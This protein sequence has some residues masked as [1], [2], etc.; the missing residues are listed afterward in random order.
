MTFSQADVKRIKAVEQRRKAAQKAARMYVMNKALFHSFKSANTTPSQRSRIF[1]AKLLFGLYGNGSD[2]PEDK[3]N[4][5]NRRRWKK[6][7]KIAKHI[8]LCD[9]NEGLSEPADMCM[10]RMYGSEKIPDA[11]PDGFYDHW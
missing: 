5:R 2:D 10:E 7:R 4:K 9:R 6:N 3:S 11:F 8:E 1:Q